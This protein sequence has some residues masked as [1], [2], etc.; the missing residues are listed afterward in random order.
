MFV[1]AVLAR[2]DS[3]EGTLEWLTLGHPQ[4]CRIT[5]D[6][7]L[8]ELRGPVLPPLGLLTGQHLVPA[9][10]TLAPGNRIVFYSDGVIE[11]RH[12]DE[13]LGVAG[14]YAH[15]ALIS[16]PS[17]ASLLTH[18]LSHIAG[19][20]ETPLEDDATVMVL[21]ILTDPTREPPPA[22]PS[23]LSRYTPSYGAVGP[24]GQRPHAVQSCGR[25]IRDP[26][27]ADGA[28]RGALS[29]SDC[30]R[31]LVDPTETSILLDRISRIEFLTKR[32]T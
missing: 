26:S 18:V 32:E 17:A 9:R 13:R 8:E 23:R 20:H 7:N 12:A 11:R 1:T 6:N 30:D 28:G 16:D 2:W 22:S 29:R 31:A 15:L 24:T 10:I 5:R 19:L 25:R 14:L 27:V 21:G 3:S 4:P